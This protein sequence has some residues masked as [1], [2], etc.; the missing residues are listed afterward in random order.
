MLHKTRI[1]AQIHMYYSNESS[2]LRNVFN[3]LALK[4]S[5]GTSTS[6]TLPL[7][8]NCCLNANSINSAH[9]ADMLRLFF[10]A[11]SLTWA[12]VASVSRTCVRLALCKL[13]LQPFN[14]LVM[15]EPT[16]HLDIQS[17]KILKQAG[18]ICKRVGW[19]IFRFLNEK[20]REDGIIFWN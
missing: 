4:A 16:N 19:T 15:D 6:A 14:V 13:L 18:L 12:W 2:S 3:R 20:Q 17:K 10:S 7:A 11:S 1:S 9:S 8:S 5:R